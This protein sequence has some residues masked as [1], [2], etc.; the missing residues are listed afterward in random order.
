VEQN[1]ASFSKRHSTLTGVA[2]EMK[3]PDYFPWRPYA[4]EH[5]HAQDDGRLDGDASPL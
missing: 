1:Q 3:Y 5:Q 4:D 2:R